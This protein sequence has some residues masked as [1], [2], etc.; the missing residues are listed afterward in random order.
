M[1]LASPLLSTKLFMPRPQPRTVARP[2]LAER[3]ASWPTR[4]LTLVSAPPGFGKTTLVSTWASSANAET[5]W[6]SLDGDDNDP[7]RFWMYVLRALS[8]PLGDFVMAAEE[9][10][11]SPAPSYKSLIAALINR[12]SESPTPV[13]LVLDDYHVITAPPI[14]DAMALFI[15]RLPE[16]MHVV[17]ATRSDPPFMLARLRAQGQMLELRAADLRFEAEEAQA[18]LNERMALGLSAN[19]LSSLTQATEGWVTGLQLAA[20][21]LQHA[22]DREA[23]V[24]A[25]AGTNRYIVDYLVEEVLHAHPPHVQHFLLKTSIL[26][27]LSGPL[28]DALLDSHGSQQILEELEQ[29]NLFLV[30]LDGERRWYRYHHLFADMLRHLL[31]RQAPASVSSLHEKASS[32]FERQG[33][34]S[35]AIHHALEGQHDARAADLIAAAAPTLGRGEIA[36]LLGWLSA[37]PA[38]RLD[39][40]PDLLLLMAWVRFPSGNHAELTSLFRRVEQALARPLEDERKRDAYAAQFVA[41]QA[42]TARARGDLA[43]TTRLSETALAALPPNEPMWRI[44]VA[45]NLATAYQHGDRPQDALRTFDLVLAEADAHDAILA[46]SLKATCLQEFGKLGEALPLFEAALRLAEAHGGRAN[47][48]TS[49]AW[50]GLAHLHLKQGR[51]DEALRCFHE[52][53]ACGEGL[54]EPHL[55]ACTQLARLYALHDEREKAERMWQE[56]HQVGQALPNVG[57]YLNALRALCLDDSGP[58]LERLVAMAPPPEAGTPRHWP[59]QDWNLLAAKA[60][61]ALGE[62]ERG[63]ARLEEVERHAQEAG[64]L[65][66]ALQAMVLRASMLPEEAP[67]LLSRAVVLAEPENLRQAFLD[68]GTSLQPLLRTLATTL[69]D[70]ATR[71]LETLI[72]PQ[73]EALAPESL[74]DPLSEREREV[75]ALIAEGLTN[76]AIAQQLVIELSTVKRH[77]TNLFGKLGATNRTQAVARARALGLL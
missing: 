41:L 48:L 68:E 31:E 7:T 45:L 13:M 21:S 75:L 1:P 16:G 57:I 26:E 34:Y 72:G 29:A 25:F 28:C 22:P 63:L 32:W 59:L 44:G 3:L 10:L 8:K 69:D 58:A 19:A 74:L 14:H 20:L 53:R 64:R 35:E 23:F 61:L 50:V 51:D 71:F 11:N 6:V 67:A 56:A 15:D 55:N 70:A 47:T 37:L 4:K 17:L 49:Y 60:L 27:R 52:G 62:R 77:G 5:A 42:F 38:F 73:S 40:R 66:L 65:P 39:Q 12:L 43:T 36:T 2:Q 18:Y 76:Q 30:P 9:I 46:M 24:S 33:H 54:L